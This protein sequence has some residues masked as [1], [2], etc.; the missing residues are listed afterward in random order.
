MIGRIK[1]DRSRREIFRK[2]DDCESSCEEIIHFDS[3]GE[4]SSDDRKNFEDSVGDGDGDEDSVG[5]GDG[6]EDSVDDGD[7]DEERIYSRRNFEDSV[8]YGDGDEDPVNDGDDDE[9]NVDD[10][11]FYINWVELGKVSPVK[12]YP[13]NCQLCWATSA[14]L[15]VESKIAIKNNTRPV[16][17][18]MQ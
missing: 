12:N 9:S 2:L 6:D 4:E 15:V 10:E 8:D 5:D 1:I 16:P 18:S 7:G 11:K 3:S 17:L 14:S 13:Y